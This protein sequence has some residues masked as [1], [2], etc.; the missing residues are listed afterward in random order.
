MSAVPRALP[1]K[2]ESS[3]SQPEKGE[4]FK[5]VRMPL[6]LKRAAPRATLQVPA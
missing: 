3:S 6:G 1:R 5:T 4:R 2:P